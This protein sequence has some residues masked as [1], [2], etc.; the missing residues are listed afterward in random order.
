MRW[1]YDPAYDYGAGIPGLPRE[2]H[3]FILRKPSEI[4]EHLIEMGVANRDVFEQ[5]EAV[6]ERELS[7]V[8]DTRVIA[9]LHDARHVAA[10]VELPELAELP[11]EIVWQVV[12]QPQLLAAGGT[13]NALRAAANGE[14]A[15]NLSGGY[16]HARR[17]LSHGFCLVNDVAL[18]I[19]RLRHEGIRRRL[20]II[21]L[22]LHQGDGNAMIFAGDRDTY[23]VSVHEENLFP[24]PKARSDLDIGLPSFTGD[25]DYLNAVDEALEHARRHFTPQLIVYIAGSDPYTGDPLGSLQL[26]KR[27]LLARDKRVARF[28]RDLRCP[29]VALPAGGYSNESPS[30]TAATFR[31][32]AEIA[33]AGGQGKGI[34]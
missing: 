26:T 20:L 4:A 30:I 16:H 19:A 22:D 21:D 25:A 34:P 10:A 29:L 6:S 18:A 8:H 28:A 9:G 27:G 33:E 31:A 12:V 15:G 17:D 23:T 32:I 5:P 24:I 1:F 14:S 13:Y 3:G 2:V 11:D 7:R